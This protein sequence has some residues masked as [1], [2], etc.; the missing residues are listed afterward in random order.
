MGEKHP[1]TLYSMNNLAVLSYNNQGQYD[2]ARPLYETYP[3]TL[4]SLQLGKLEEEE[5]SSRPPQ[6]SA[7][8]AGTGGNGRQIDSICI[9]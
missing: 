7:I 5:E 9:H 6:A 8:F 2:Q 4:H 3:D 1:N